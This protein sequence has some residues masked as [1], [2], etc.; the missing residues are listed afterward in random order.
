MCI[1]DRSIEWPVGTRAPIQVGV[2]ICYELLFPHLVRR[3]GADGAGV[4]LAVTNDAWY[5]RTGAPHQFLAMTALRAAENGLPVVRAANTGISAII[6]ARGRIVRSG[7]LFE[8]AVVIGEIER[9]GGKGPTFYA[10]FGDGFAGL[11]LVA[12]IGLALRRGLG[13]SRRRRQRAVAGAADEHED[14][15]G[16]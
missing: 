14:S 13:E 15:T 4:L 16:A 6:D 5:G 7:S 10:R 2:P 11:C 12:A 1:R 9:G 3:F 8:E